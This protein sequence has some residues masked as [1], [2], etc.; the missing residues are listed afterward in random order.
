MS[1]EIL[2]K[3]EYTDKLIFNDIGNQF[4]LTHMFWNSQSAA[5]LAKSATLV[6]K[7]R[8]TSLQNMFPWAPVWRL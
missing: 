2:L 4:L 6:L 1:C 5:T 7:F 8:V 3:K